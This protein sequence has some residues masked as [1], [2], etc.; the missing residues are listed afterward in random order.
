MLDR[1]RDREGGGFRFTATDS[2]ALLIE[3]KEIY[4]GAVPSGNAVASLVLQKLGALLADPDLAREGREVLETFAGHLEATPLAYPQMMLALD[5]ALGPTAEVVLAGNPTSA[6]LLAMRQE[7]DGRF[8][9]RVSVAVLP[10]GKAGERLKA[11]SPFLAGLDPARGP[12]T[13]YV[14]QDGRCALPTAELGVMLEQVT[15]VGQAAMAGDRT[16]AE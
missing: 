7:L 10:E 13:A 16:A 12:A 6:E 1:F 2:E 3:T 4:D 8:L 15:T 5:L 9:P 11:L 14:C